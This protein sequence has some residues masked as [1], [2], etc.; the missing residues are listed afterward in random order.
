MIRYLL[1]F[2]AR[3][4]LQQL[5]RCQGAWGHVDYPALLLFELL[6]PYWLNTHTDG[7]LCG[8]LKACSQLFNSDAHA[9]GS[10]VVL[11]VLLVV[12]DTEMKGLFG[13]ALKGVT[14]NGGKWL[15]MATATTTRVRELLDC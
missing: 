6:Q 4:S 10:T 14:E 9:Q 13:F 7:K 12:T 8:G 3:L 11:L 5:Q 1:T 15:A 2:Q